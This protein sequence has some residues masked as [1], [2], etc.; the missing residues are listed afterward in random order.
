MP[1]N[2][3][4]HSQ[5]A[6]RLGRFADGFTQQNTDSIG[7]LGYITQHPAYRIGSSLFDKVADRHI[8][9]MCEDVLAQ[10][11]SSNKDDFFAEVFLEEGRKAPENSDKENRNHYINHNPHPAGCGLARVDKCRERLCPSNKKMLRGNSKFNSLHME[12]LIRVHSF[13]LHREG[14]GFC[15]SQFFEQ[16]GC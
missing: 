1:V 16:F 7:A 8:H 9:H 12:S 3:Q 10:S 6:Y 2:P 15:R 11:C 13:N 14:S 4:R 5:H